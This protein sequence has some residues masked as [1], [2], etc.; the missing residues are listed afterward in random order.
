MGSARTAV[1][2][3]AVDAVDLEGLAVEQ[4]LP[5][6]RLD[7]PDPETLAES[8]DRMSPLLQGRDELVQCGDSGD[9]GSA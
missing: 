7:R 4:Q 5:A 2:V 6:P 9:Q 3:V 8:I 1:L